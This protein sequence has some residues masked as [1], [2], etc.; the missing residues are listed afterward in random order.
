MTTGETKFIEWVL[1][2]LGMGLVF[3]GWRTI[4]KKR[5]TAD[6]REYAGRSAVHL[7]WLWIVIGILLI[8]AVIFNISFLKSFG[9]LF[10]ETAS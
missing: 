4:H 1:L 8:L 3:S 7:G 6:G 10:M 2:M 9:K 5:T